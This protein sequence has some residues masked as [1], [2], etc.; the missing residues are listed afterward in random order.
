[1]TTESI[2]NDGSGKGRVSITYPFSTIQSASSVTI[3][4]YSPTP[5]FKGSS[6]SQSKLYGGTP[7]LMF[8]DT[9]PVFSFKQES[10]VAIVYCK[11]ESGSYTLKE[12]VFEHPL[13]SKT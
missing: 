6:P 13:L 7:P 4:L 10:V 11:I 8:T 12:E 2:T 1:M 3:T 5:I 9:F